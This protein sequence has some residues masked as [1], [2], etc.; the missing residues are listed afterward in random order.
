MANAMQPLVVQPEDGEA[1]TG[2]TGGTL[3]FKARGKETNWG[4]TAFTNEI[5]PGAGPPL[6]VHA[7]ED[8]LWYVIEGS[9]RLQLGDEIRPASSGSVVFIPRGTPHCFENIGDGW[10]RQLIVFTPAGMERLY[11]QLFPSLT[12][13]PDAGAFARFGEPLGTRVVGPA[14]SKTHPPVRPAPS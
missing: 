2:P 3:R 13:G 7:H 12:S 8:E 4:V 5:P 10:V 11:E 6:H 1:L 9:L 14:L